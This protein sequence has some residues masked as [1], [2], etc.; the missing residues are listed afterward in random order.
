M[1][2]KT[3]SYFELPS[4]VGARESETTLSYAKVTKITSVLRH[5]SPWAKFPAL[6]SLS[7]HVQLS[8]GGRTIL[9]P[10]ESWCQ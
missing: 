7:G 6:I 5:W 3:P 8:Q 10:K 1:T 4:C 2:Q 9:L